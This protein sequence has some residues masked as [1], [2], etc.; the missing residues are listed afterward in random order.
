MQM[1]DA[2]KIS[3]S[4]DGD[5]NVN[6]PITEVVEL[7]CRMILGI[8]EQTGVDPGELVSVIAQYVIAVGGEPVGGDS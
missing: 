4:S 5:L 8:A 7:V 6:G 2:T 3:I 1:S